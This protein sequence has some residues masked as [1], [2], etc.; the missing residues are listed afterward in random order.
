MKTNILF[1]V[2]FLISLNVFAQQKDSYLINTDTI[3]SS[4]TIRL[5][6]DVIVN[7]PASLTIAEGVFIEFQGNYSITVFGRISA[8]GTINDTIIFTINNAELIDDTTTNA[9]GWGGIKLLSNEIDTSIFEYC[10]FSYGKAIA[11]GTSWDNPYNEDNKGGAI[12]ITEYGHFHANNCTFYH[13]R[14]NYA[15]GGI[16]VNE[17]NTFKI[18]SNCFKYN[19]AYFIG[20]GVF[21]ESSSYS[22]IYNNLF[23][24]NE[25]F[26]TTTVS[27]GGAGSG[28]ALYDNAVV[29]SN[30]F[31][32]NTSVSG[33][34]YESSYNSIIINN[35]SA[36]NKGAGM[37]FAGW[38]HGISKLINNIIVNNKSFLPGGCGILFFGDKAVMR[39]NIVSG[40]TSYIEGIDPIQVWTPRE[41]IADFA[42]SCNPDEPVYYQGEGNIHEDPQ[43]INPT[44]GAGPDYDGLAADWSLLDSSP[45]VNTGTPDT[46]GLNLPATDL[47]GN[48]RIYGIRVDMGAI[49]NQMVVGLPQNPLVNARIQVS[50]NPFGQSFKVIAPGRAKISSICLFN[51]NGQQIATETRMPFEQM[52]VFDL[53]NQSPGLYLLLTRFADGSAETTKLVKY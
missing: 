19:S 24:V 52:L 45:C 47:L 43:F 49:E 25:S 33:A 34:M 51:Q 4:D 23:Y 39:N 31:F 28:L 37:L 22:L 15:G 18:N 40:N 5:Y 11:P 29:L 16:Y 6:S 9:G 30:L 21:I 20:G 48:P 41:V 7:Y 26:Y 32:N 17:C 44:S 42:Y 14:A 10:K 38:D 3:W 53:H 35:I 13:N 46:T 27:V 12:Y 2:L 36:N 50:P 1:I 8:R